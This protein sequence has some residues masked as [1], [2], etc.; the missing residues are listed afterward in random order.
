MGLLEAESDFEFAACWCCCGRRRVLL[1]VLARLARLSGFARN[2]SPIFGG[3]FRST[4]PFQLSFTAGGARSAGCCTME[5]RSRG[6]RVSTP[7]EAL[8]AGRPP[9]PMRRDRRV[10]STRARASSGTEESS[11]VRSDETE[12]KIRNTL[13]HCLSSTSL[14]RGVKRKVRSRPVPRERARPRL[15]RN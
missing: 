5:S 13:G 1:P 11:F 9:R 15:S 14:R 12:E 3:F 8:G 10:P 7:R 6:V 2:L 4:C